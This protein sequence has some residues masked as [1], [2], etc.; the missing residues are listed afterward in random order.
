MIP[1]NH[2]GGHLVLFSPAKVNLFFRVIK[3]RLDG[4]HEIASLYQSLSLGDQL[5]VKCADEDRLT[6]DDPTLA[7]DRSNLVLRAADL[8]RK[9][10]GL[11]IHAHFHLLKRI[12]I[13]AGLGGGSSNAATTLWALNTLAGSPASLSE[14]KLWSAEIGSDVSFFFSNGT[15]YCEGR[16]EILSNLA[17]LSIQK[18]WI[19]KP[20]SGLS[21]P[22]VYQNTQVATLEAR[23][24]KQALASFFDG[25]PHFFNDLEPASFKLAPELLT[26]KHELNQNF[27]DVVMTGSG[28]A[29]FCLGKEVAPNIA[30]VDFYPVDFVRRSEEKWYEFPTFC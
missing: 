4:Y 29:F 2:F 20:K 6:C 1:P 13:Q 17:P 28:T 19:A 23:D 9:K 24:P 27:E 7:C 21:T 3:K 12:P 18:G 5:E 26:L 22:L 30:K 15:A 11:A 25:K 10:T 16:G 14:L 8:F